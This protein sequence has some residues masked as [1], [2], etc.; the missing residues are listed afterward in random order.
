M[1]SLV[2]GAARQKM[3]DIPHFFFLVSNSIKNRKRQYQRWRRRRGKMKRTEWGRTVTFHFHSELRQK[4]GN[5]YSVTRKEIRNRCRETGACI[6]EK[7]FSCNNT[8]LFI[9]TV[10]LPIPH[11]ECDL[12]HT[13]TPLKVK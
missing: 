3:T 1:L 5:H 8:F 9:F 4:K 6:I 7:C 13:I 10:R 11:P 2:C 12:F